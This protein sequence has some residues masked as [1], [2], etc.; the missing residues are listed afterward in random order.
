MVQAY[1]RGALSHGDAFLE[2]VSSPEME[3]AMP[4]CSGGFHA[5]A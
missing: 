3:K 1:K 5:V 2:R 4:C